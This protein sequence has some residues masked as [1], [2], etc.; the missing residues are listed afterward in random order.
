MPTDIPWWYDDD[1][2]WD[3]LHMGGFTWPGECEVKVKNGQKIDRKAAAGKAGEK[4]TL[5]GV[6]SADVTIRLRFDAR[7]DWVTLQGAIEEIQ[8]LARGQKTLTPLTIVHPVTSFWFITDIV[9]E[10]IDGPNDTGTKGVKELVFQCIEF[11]ASAQVNEKKGSAT[12]TPKTALD[13]A[14]TGT[15]L[16]DIAH[17]A[18]LFAESVFNETVDRAGQAL[19]FPPS[20]FGPPPPP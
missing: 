1:T 14:E 3:K 10:N 5:Q 13:K 18:N 7:E 12:S 11:D 2:A 19:G 17:D 16:G 15:T 6:K 9:I 4:L 8:V 20:Q